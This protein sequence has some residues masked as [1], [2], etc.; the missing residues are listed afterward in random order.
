VTRTAEPRTTR[1]ARAI[2]A[3]S[4]V[5]AMLVS[6]GASHAQDSTDDAAPATEGS[7]DSAPAG[8]AEGSGG[9]AEEFIFELYDPDTV[10]PLLDMPDDDELIVLAP[11]PAPD[12]TRDRWY[13]QTGRVRV[14]IA[15]GQDE[16]VNPT[17][18]FDW[19][20]A[21]LEG[22]ADPSVFDVEKVALRLWAQLGADFE[23]GGGAATSGLPTAR[24]GLIAYVDRLGVSERARLYDGRRLWGVVDFVRNARLARSHSLRAS[25]IGYAVTVV[26]PDRSR[27]TTALELEARGPGYAYQSGMRRAGM[28]HGASLGGFEADFG[29]VAP[30]GPRADVLA[31]IGTAAHVA[32]GADEGGRFTARTDAETRARAG[33]RFVERFEFALAGGYGAATDSFYTERRE[34]WFAR[35]HFGVGW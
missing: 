13:R 24:V 34:D 3:T 19:S 27:A 30:V 14:G 8:P 21:L 9:T 2:A 23:I 16:I 7:A 11:A 17:F 1:P 33:V 6:S 15:T 26:V 5:V 20:A 4:V 12:P 32:L 35:L 22:D 28:F 25:P 18:G 31:S 29:T 10:L